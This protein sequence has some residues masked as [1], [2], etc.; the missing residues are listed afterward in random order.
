MKKSKNT[1]YFSRA[2]VVVVCWWMISLLIFHMRHPWM[3][4]MEVFMSSWQAITMQSVG[5]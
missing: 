4:N 3:T 1:D 5:R 2:F